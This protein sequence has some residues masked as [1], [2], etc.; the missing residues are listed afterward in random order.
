MRKTNHFSAWGGTQT[1][2]SRVNCKLNRTRMVETDEII[3]PSG[4]A[5][6][7]T[8]PAPVPE[9]KP[10]QAEAA[11]E[12]PKAEEK[13]AEKPEAKAEAPKPVKREVWNMPVTKA[14]EEKRRAVEKAK[15]DAEAQYKAELDKMKAEYEAKLR[16]TKPESALDEIAERH[17]LDKEAARDLAD[18]IKSTIKLPDLSRYDQI[19]QEREIE[20][21]KL[22][23]SK[24]FDE[25]V[26]PIIRKEYPDATPEHIREVKERIGDLA[27]TDGYN[28]Y[29]VEDI[30]QVKRDEFVFKNQMGAEAP[31]GRGPDLAPFK[32]LSDEE[33]IAL[34][35]SDNAAYRRYLSWLRTQESKFIG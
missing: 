30:Y 16:S 22:Q 35:D 29:R 2:S 34:A 6:T 13:A 10:E 26:A 18:A 12:A 24:E 19:L 1:P 7:E 31:R 14:Q 25:K 32:R 23:V 33:E 8:T 5:D 17:G 27:F 11:P 21:H 9:K 20:A 15:A 4:E 3:E 28:T